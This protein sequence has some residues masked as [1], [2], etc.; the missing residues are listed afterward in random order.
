MQDDRDRQVERGMRLAA[1]R[2][3]VMPDQADARI[4]P[5]Y[6]DIQRTLRVPF[7]NLIFRTLANDPDYFEPAWRGIAPVL[8]M[9]AFEGAADDLRAQ[10]LLEPVPEAFGAEL[11][12]MADL[13]R[14]RAFNDSIHYVLPKLLLIVSALD[15]AGFGQ[16]S[17]GTSR[18]PPEDSSAQIPLGIAEGTAKVGMIDPAQAG[19]ALEDLFERIKTRHG[20]PLVSSYY[21][22]LANWPD[23]LEAGWRRIEP[24]VGSDAYET[25]KRLLVDQARSAS[26]DLPDGGAPAADADVNRTEEIRALLAAF[27]FKFIPEMLIDVALI[28]AMLD[29]PQAAT[30]SR[31]SA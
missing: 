9:H 12:G 21:R 18:K 4:Q 3:E 28:K 16:A 11:E 10:A 8:R 25:R 24:L 13:D 23:F 22:G 26:R 29:G 5:I 2:P 7:V 6:E 31:F 30:S 17:D 14:L 1:E 19:G 20:H 27:R 15:A